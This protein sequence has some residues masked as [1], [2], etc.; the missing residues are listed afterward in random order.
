MHPDL[1]LGLLALILFVL[2][3]R[4]STMVQAGRNGAGD[5]SRWEGL[6]SGE[7]GWE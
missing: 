6:W 5:S 1:T 4:G 3:D 7:G 2:S